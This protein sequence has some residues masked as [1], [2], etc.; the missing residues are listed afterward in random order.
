MRREELGLS[1]AHEGRNPDAWHEPT[2][3]HGGGN[4]RKAMRELLAIWMQPVTHAR[5]AVIHLKRGSALPKREAP[6]AV[7][8]RIQVMQQALLRDVRVVPIPA[9]IANQR[10]AGQR[11]NATERKPAL[12]GLVD[13]PGTHDGKPHKAAPLARRNG[14]GRRLLAHEKLAC[15]KVLAD[16]RHSR[17]LAQRAHE[18]G[19]AIPTQVAIGKSMLV[20]GSLIRLHKA[21]VAGGVEHPVSYGC[22]RHP[23]VAHAVARVSLDGIGPGVVAVEIERRGL[24]KR[25]RQRCLHGI[26]NDLA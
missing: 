10:R 19:L 18:G 20:P 5:V 24:V 9:G 26:D 3:A 8:K 15:R 2:L 22:A 13:A 1:L 7:R 25:S 23:E 17:V 4:R 12:C 16:E 14:N 11:A 6:Q 21:V